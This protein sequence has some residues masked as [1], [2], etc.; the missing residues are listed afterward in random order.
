VASCGDTTT[1][2]INKFDAL[3]SFSGLLVTGACLQVRTCSGGPR[4]LAVLEAPR[5]AGTVFAARFHRGD[6]GAETEPPL[7]AAEQAD[8][9]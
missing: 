2:S 9:S 3:K 4:C 5:P 1:I 7:G 6:S 8:G